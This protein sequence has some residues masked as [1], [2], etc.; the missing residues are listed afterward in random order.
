MC[1]FFQYGP[2]KM[3]RTPKFMAHVGDQFEVVKSH[4]GLLRSQ[5]N[6]PKK[7]G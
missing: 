7:P 2:R 5:K 1:N 6:G 4:S 3:L